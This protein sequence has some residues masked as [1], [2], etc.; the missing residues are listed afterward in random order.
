M[1][2]GTYCS[3]VDLEIS[4]KIKLICVSTNYYWLIPFCAVNSIFKTFSY[5]C[6]IYVA[7]VLFI[8]F[9]QLLPSKV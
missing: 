3:Y 7:E 1:R 2:F 9:L 5:V 4:S 8:Q 6:Q